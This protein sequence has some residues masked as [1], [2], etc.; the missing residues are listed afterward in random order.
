MLRAV[1][2]RHPTPETHPSVTLRR[3]CH[4][5]PVARLARGFQFRYSHHPR[6]R[7]IP[8]LR[9]RDGDHPD[10]VL[11]HLVPGV[12]VQCQREHL[13]PDRHEP[14]PGQQ[15][16]HRAWE[17]H[18]RSSRHRVGIANRRHDPAVG[19]PF[20]RRRQRAERDPGDHRRPSGRHRPGFRPRGGH[21]PGGPRR[22]R[23]HPDQRQSQ[24]DRLPRSET[25][26]PGH[27]R[28]PSPRTAWS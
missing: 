10:H 26:R 6:H 28:A 24:G 5:L 14:A 21:R 25:F 22:R 11:P 18:G 13:E 4:A 20:P 17:G 1:G 8:H 15:A 3:V 9:G 7:H 2:W 23:R 12:H 19:G 27:A 16:D